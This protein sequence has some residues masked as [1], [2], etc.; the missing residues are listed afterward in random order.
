MH[1]TC[2]PSG[3]SVTAGMSSP[4]PTA[5][6]SHGP[7]QHEMPLLSQA[8]IQWSLF[9]RAGFALPFSPHPTLSVPNSSI[10]EAVPSSSVSFPQLSPPAT[11]RCC[12]EIHFGPLA[13][14]FPQRRPG[15]H[16]A[17]PETRAPG[18]SPDARALPARCTT[19]RSLP[20]TSCVGHAPDLLSLPLPVPSLSPLPTKLIL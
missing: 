11:P 7:R 19:C 3:S 5:P 9:C 20:C 12:L 16:V 6:L 4:F 1:P 13:V 18:L 10:S 2:F 15:H 17:V 8:G 14:I